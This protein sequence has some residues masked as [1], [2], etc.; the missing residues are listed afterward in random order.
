MF[1]SFDSVITDYLFDCNRSDFTESKEHDEQMQFI[2]E[3]WFKERKWPFSLTEFEES[4]MLPS[5]YNGMLRPT[6]QTTR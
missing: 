1:L 4:G 5:G 6:Q 2:V 3:D